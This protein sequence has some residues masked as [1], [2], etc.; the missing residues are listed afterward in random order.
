MRKQVA[1]VILLMVG[2]AG[3]G[4]SAVVTRALAQ[5]RSLS[6]VDQEHQLGPTPTPHWYW[7][8]VDWRLGEGYAKGHRLAPKLR[9]QSAPRRVP[10]WAWQRLHFFLVARHD[11]VLRVA[12]AGNKHHGPPKTTT[13]TTTTTPST[14]TT[15]TT[16]PTTTT[17]TTTTTTSSGSETYDSATSYTQTRPTFVP[18]RTIIVSN[19]SELKAAITDLQAGDLVKAAASFTVSGE[20]VIAKRLS[21]PAVIDLTGYA[22]H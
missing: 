16:T 12:E 8:W 6:A 4:S 10:S 19:A 13:S 22:V 1:L 9:P 18:I 11:Q 20:T 3:A 17:T 5:S 2:F 21:A 15:T 7:R 14:T